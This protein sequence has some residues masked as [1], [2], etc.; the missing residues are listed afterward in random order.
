MGTVDDTACSSMPYPEMYTRDVAEWI[1]TGHP[2]SMSAWAGVVSWS[3]YMMTV[4]T[5]FDWQCYGWFTLGLKGFC[6]GRVLEH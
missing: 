2:A 1:G 6:R 4:V 5:L 3:Y